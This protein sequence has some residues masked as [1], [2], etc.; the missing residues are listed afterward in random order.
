GSASPRV[1]ITDSCPHLVKDRQAR[2]PRCARGAA[3]ARKGAGRALGRQNGRGRG[4]GP[5]PAPR[6]PRHGGAPLAPTR[7]QRGDDRLAPPRPSPRSP[8]SRGGAPRRGRRGRRLPR[9]PLWRGR[10]TPRCAG[11]HG[12]GERGRVRERL[13]RP[14]PRL[15][16]P[17]RRPSALA[18]IDAHERAHVV[19]RPHDAER[20]HRPAAPR[21]PDLAHRRP[22][23]PAAAAA[24]APAR[25]SLARREVDV[26]GARARPQRVARLARRAGR[27]REARDAPRARAQ[28]RAVVEGLSGTGQAQEQHADEG[29]RGGERALFLVS[30]SLCSS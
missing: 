29:V 6:L 7:P 15:A 22:P 19:G 30:L 28:R 17:A 21:A 18:A 27:G 20:R 12:D 11:R 24:R 26:V 2:A 4:P 16:A 9:A 14:R 10:R 8:C 23:P 3:Q 5:G 1:F 13:G 25:C